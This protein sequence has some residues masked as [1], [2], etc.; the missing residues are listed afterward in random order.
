MAGGRAVRVPL[1][2]VASSPSGGGSG[3]W[4]IAQ[5]PMAIAA[6]AVHAKLYFTCSIL[7]LVAMEE[8][9]TCHPRPRWRV[10]KI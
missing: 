3:G 1:T 2:R 8:P 6:N 10:P 5:P 7:S 9:A 4:S